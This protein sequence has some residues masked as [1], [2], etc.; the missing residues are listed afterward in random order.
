MTKQLGFL[1]NSEKC[2]GCRGCEMACKNEY[3][4]DA[5]P[6]WR[7]VFQL[8]EEDYSLPTRM[9]F[10]MACNH[11]ANPECLRVCPVKA[12][13]KREDGIV[14][15]D[16]DRCIGCRLCLMACPYDRPQFNPAQKKVEKCNL[17]YQRIDK[18]EKPACVAACIPEALQLVEINE[19]L[20]QKMGVLKTLPG[21]PSPDI[22]Q[23]AIRFIGPKQGKQI[24]RD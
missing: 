19:G 15:H 11:C 7:Q 1:H 12:Y 23:P 5:A 18:G 4:T 20:D 2:V 17:C 22:T 9:F 16:H 21:L 14:V 24:R 8:R 6:R 3:Q 13:T 10:S